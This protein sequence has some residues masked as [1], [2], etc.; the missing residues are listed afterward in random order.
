[1]KYVL[2]TLKYAMGIAVI[3]GGIGLALYVGIHLFMVNGAINMS[4]GI[5]AN[6][7]GF[8]RLPLGFVE[9]SCLCTLS[10]IY[11]WRPF[12]I[13]GILIMSLGE[14]DDPMNLEGEEEE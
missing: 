10:L 1:M 3:L 12:A 9:A 11:L 6:S 14:T 5:T 2:G 13:G 7:I 4:E 8:Y